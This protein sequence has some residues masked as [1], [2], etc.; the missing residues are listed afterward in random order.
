MPGG[1]TAISMQYKNEFICKWNL[2][3]S[4]EK[5]NKVILVYA[6]TRGNTGS[7]DEEFHY[8][9]AYLL[10]GLKDI[11]DLLLNGNIVIDF[12]IDQKVGDR[13]GPHDRGPHIRMPKS[14]ITQSYE[15]IKIALE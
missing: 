12:C 5:I 7:S 2:E 8:V 3:D 11:N 14:R 6:E 13:K 10:N 4:L 9:R 15:E 1:S